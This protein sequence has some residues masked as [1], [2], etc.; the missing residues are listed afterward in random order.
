NQVTYTYSRAVGRHLWKI[1][2][3]LNRVHLEAATADGFSATYLFANFAD[4]AAGR[5][6]Q[7][8]QTLGTI[9]TN[10]AVQKLGAFVQDHWS[11]GRNL[12]IDFGLRYDIERLP[13]PFP[14]DAHNVSPRVGVAW[15]PAPGWVVRS[16][17]G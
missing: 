5:P 1:G 11:T 9:G 6:S 13:P 3:A 14:V 10:F 15:H 12:T 17:Y 8:R 2:A 4:F 7:L 16:G